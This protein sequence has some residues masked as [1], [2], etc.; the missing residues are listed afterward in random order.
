MKLE[1]GAT[2]FGLAPLRAFAA[3]AAAAALAAS[4]SIFAALRAALL[5][6]FGAMLG[7]A[8][9]LGRLLSSGF[10]GAGTGALSPVPFVLDFVADEVDGF[11]RIA[12]TEEARGTAYLEGVPEAC[13]AGRT[14]AAKDGLGA[15]DE[16]E[17][18]RDR[19]AALT[20]DPD[21]TKQ[22]MH[23]IFNRLTDSITVVLTRSRWSSLLLFLFLLLLLSP[24]RRTLIQP[25]SHS[26]RF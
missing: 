25:G 1:G 20:A 17:D 21:R 11:G 4:A 12:V 9:L 16:P 24:Q 14:I 2:L 23:K 3:A 7:A 15:T 10:G 26:R 6:I 18:A 22:R 13:E 5:F 19:E 8:T